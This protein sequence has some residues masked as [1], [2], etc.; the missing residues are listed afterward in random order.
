[1]SM[2]RIRFALV[3]FLLLLAGQAA[4]ANHVVS[5]GGESLAFFPANLEIKVG[6]TVTFRNNGGIHNVVSDGNFRCA[7]GCD[8]SGG[9]GSTSD[10]DWSFTLT[11]NEP[12]LIKYYCQA[13]GTPNTGM[14]GSIAVK[15]A[16]PSLVLGPG[17]SGNW[18]NPSQDGHGFQL[19]AVTDTIFTAFWFVFDNN[20]NQA[21]ISGVGERNGNQIVMSAARVTGGHFPPN[22]D[23]N[24]V[25]KPSWGTLTFTFSDCTHGAVDWTSTD[26]A[27]TPAGHLDLMRVTQIFGTTCP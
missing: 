22:F 25:Q 26:T 27:F 2:Q 6:D 18:F 21:W 4:A 16:D 12:G 8:G 23:P 3:L 11:F 15:A 20:G 7:K 1:M 9:S 14:H 19:E 24:A 5:V 10:D 13:H 17:F